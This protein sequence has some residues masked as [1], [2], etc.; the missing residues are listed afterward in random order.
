MRARASQRG[1]TLLELMTAVGVASIFITLMG[2]GVVYQQRA[3][4]E[5]LDGSDAQQNARA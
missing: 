4:F 3:L 5:Q 1:F 2:A